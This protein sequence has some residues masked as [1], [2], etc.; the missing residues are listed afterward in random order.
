MKTKEQTPSHIPEYEI[1]YMFVGILFYNFIPLLTRDSNVSKVCFLLR[2]FEVFQG[3]IV[4]WDTGTA[5]FKSFWCFLGA[6]Y[7]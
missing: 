5:S 2:C 6:K 1:V 3:M 4:S 7:S